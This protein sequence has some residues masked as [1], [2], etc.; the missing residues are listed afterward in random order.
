MHGNKNL[1][2]G[3]HKST[4]LKKNGKEVTENEEQGQREYGLQFVC[5]PSNNTTMSCMAWMQCISKGH[6]GELHS[7]FFSLIPPHS[8]PLYISLDPWK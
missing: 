6:N 2:E 5:D 3:E 1:G 8:T 4:T 7:F